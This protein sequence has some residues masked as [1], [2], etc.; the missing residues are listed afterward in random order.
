MH[1]IKQQ[2]TTIQ[3]APFRCRPDFP[4]QQANNSI[5]IFGIAQWMPNK[6]KIIDHKSEARAQGGGLLI[7][8]F[9][10]TYNNNLKSKSSVSKY[11]QQS[12]YSPKLLSKQNKQL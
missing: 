9:F 2:G 4:F 7:P 6:I 5:T 8:H 11:Y 3:I 1:H 12:K 10:Y